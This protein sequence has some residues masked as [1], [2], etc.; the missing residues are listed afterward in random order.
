LYVSFAQRE[1][2]IAPPYTVELGLTGI[3]DAHI[4][5]PENQLWGPI[6]QPSLSHRVVLHRLDEGALKSLLAEF[7]E[8][9][10]DLAGYSR[11]KNL[12]GF[13]G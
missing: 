12:Y 5:M 2:E 9:M 1:L 8:K 4:A 6:H 3:R 13:P 10:Y 11:P 7:F